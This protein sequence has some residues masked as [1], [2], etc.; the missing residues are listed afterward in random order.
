MVRMPKNKANISSR[1]RNIFLTKNSRVASIVY[2]VTTLLTFGITLII[3]NMF[4]EKDTIIAGTNLSLALL[5]LNIILGIVSFVAIFLN[6]SKNKKN[7][8][9]PFYVKNAI[10]ISIGYI[11]LNSVIFVGAG[12]KEKMNR[13]NNSSVKESAVY[14]SPTPISEPTST[15]IPILKQANKVIATPTV[16]EKIINCYINNEC[17][18]GT[19]KLTESEC[20]ELVCCGTNN[21]YVLIKKSECDKVHTNTSTT[22]NNSSIEM[23]AVTLPHNGK[24]VYCPKGIDAQAY[25]LSLQ[26][27]ETIEYFKT[28]G[29][30]FDEDG[31]VESKL[32]DFMSSNKCKY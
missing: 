7:T 11:F 31:K 16:G 4:L 25:N 6:S 15:P 13:Q 14:V 20:K 28:I 22:N 18:G 2:W 24:M 12:Y 23:V 8:K 27:K 10:F 32:N 1:I 30:V 26:L 9:L 29:S 19:R 3:I 5:L 21:T 17:G